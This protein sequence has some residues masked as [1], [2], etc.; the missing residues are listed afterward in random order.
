[1][2]ECADCDDGDDENLF[3]RVRLVGE[4]ANEGRSFE[5][6]GSGR[7]AGGPFRCCCS[8]SVA[9]AWWRSSS[10]WVPLLPTLVALLS[11]ASSAFFASDAQLG[12]MYAKLDEIQESIRVSK[13]YV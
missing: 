5:S 9:S 3:Q 12:I 2:S 1:M 6:C 7:D 13:Q 11:W 10:S 4:G 8:S